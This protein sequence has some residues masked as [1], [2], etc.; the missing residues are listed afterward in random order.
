MQ[1]R[2]IASYSYIWLQL[3]ISLQYIAIHVHPMQVYTYVFDIVHAVPCNTCASLVPLC[4]NTKEYVRS[5]TDSPH[6]CP[7]WNNIRTA[8]NTIYTVCHTL[9]P[10]KCRAKNSHG[11][12]VNS[13]DGRLV[14]LLAVLPRPLHIRPS[15][16]R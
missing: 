2:Y 15:G 9:A 16:H 3:V 13:K 10:H 4:Q 1:Y 12:N 7:R 8:W 11:C 6:S 14:L 5:Y